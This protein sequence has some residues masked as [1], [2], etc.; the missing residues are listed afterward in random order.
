LAFALARQ[1]ANVVIADISGERA[2]DAAS[3]VREATGVRTLGVETDVSDVA[4]V[5]ALADT[6]F[7]TFGNVHGLANNAGV[8]TAGLSWELRS[9]TGRWPSAST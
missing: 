2:A 4:S 7:T 3:Q 8:T 9:R 5:E 1:G 6:A